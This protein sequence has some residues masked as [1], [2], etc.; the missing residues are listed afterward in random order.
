MSF[1]KL[2]WRVLWSKSLNKKDNIEQEVTTDTE[3]KWGG[4]S[5]KEK[6]VQ[7]KGNFSA[8]KTQV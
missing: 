3:W 5:G 8:V 7:N 4:K 1:L 6:L 2:K